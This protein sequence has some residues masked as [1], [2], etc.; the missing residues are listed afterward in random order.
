MTYEIQV[1]IRSHRPLPLPL[2]TPT[3]RRDVPTLPAKHRKPSPLLSRSGDTEAD[4]L[5]VAALK[6][7]ARHQGVRRGRLGCVPALLLCLSYR[8]SD[9]GARPGL[10]VGRFRLSPASTRRIREATSRSDAE[11]IG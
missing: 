4:S 6:L 8:D 5:T 9:L 11:Q 3:K 10:T 2:G 7:A 1:T